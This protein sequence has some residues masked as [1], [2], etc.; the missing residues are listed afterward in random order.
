[1]SQPV[2]VAAITLTI[3]IG[4]MAPIVIVTLS[5]NRE[6]RALQL[7]TIGAIIAFV[8]TLLECAHLRFNFTNSVPVG[9]YSLRPIRSVGLKRG[10]L[11][12]ACPPAAAAE[13]GRKRGY[14]GRG[15]CTG[16][17]EPLLKYVAALGRDE[18]D[19]T[20]RGITVNG[21]L[22]PESRTVVLDRSGRPLAAWPRGHY[23]LA[24]GQVWLY[25]PDARSWDS[26]YWGPS[27]GANVIAEALALLALPGKL[28][29]ADC[30]P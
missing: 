27:Q 11:I 5:D 12:A 18:V 2:L 10:M 29:A 15:A 7:T 17:T 1:M 24:S 19:V 14:L 9:I 13:L 30:I 22:L 3:A 23:R 21:C 6:G 8:I 28:T 20:P 16:E 4:V 25:A 26:R